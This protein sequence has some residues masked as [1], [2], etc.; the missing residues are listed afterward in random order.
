LEGEPSILCARFV[1]HNIDDTTYTT[2]W[3]VLDRR[4]GGQNREDQQVMDEFEKVRVLESYDLKEV[5]ALADCLV[6]V[7][8]YYRK[9][10][11]G[12]LIQPRGLL[13]QK[14]K[15]KLGQKAGVDYLKYLAEQGKDDTFLELANFLNERYRIAQ[16]IEREFAKTGK[17]SVNYTD[18]YQVK[19]SE[20]DS[21]EQGSDIDCGKF[22]A[23]GKSGSKSC[24]PTQKKWK[25]QNVSSGS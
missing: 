3:E 13:A 24:P 9:V 1:R 21:F 23:Q 16:R 11:P 19:V 14:A 5:Q 17:R 15:K 25:N 2:L 20:N 18:T 8:D 4:Y 22:N 7:R 6:S 12:S 10:D